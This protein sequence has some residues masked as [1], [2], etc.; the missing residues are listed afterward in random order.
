MHAAIFILFSGKLP[1]NFYFSFL[2]AKNNF[3]IRRQ[4]DRK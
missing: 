2:D 4:N 1:Q 3:I